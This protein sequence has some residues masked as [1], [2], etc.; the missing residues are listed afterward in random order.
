MLARAA[1]DAGFEPLVIDEYGDLDTRRAAIDFRYLRYAGSRI[2]ERAL[3]AALDDFAK[4]YGPATLCWT[5]G[6]EASAYILCALQSRYRIVGSEPRALLRLADPGWY[7]PFGEKYFASTFYSRPSKRCLV[8]DRMRAGGHAVNWR[9]NQRFLRAGAF[10]QPYL[11]GKSLSVVCL[12]SAE[13]VEIVGWNEHFEMQPNAAFPFRYS[14]AVKINPPISDKLLRALL[15]QVANK[16]GISGAFGCDVI[17]H[18]DDQFTLVDVNPR[19]TATAPLH[20]AL[21]DVLNYHIAPA[22]LASDVSTRIQ[23]HQQGAGHA[24]V[25]AD[26]PIN[27]PK[28]LNWPAW[29]SDIPNRTGLFANGEPL[30]SIWVETPQLNNAKQL[31]KRRLG[32]LEALIKEG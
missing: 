20:L 15:T 13:G 11:S 16:L 23:H 22:R 4:S 7:S 6:W 26:V 29:V 12:A 19:P 5:S 32:E 18:E 30:C 3:Y 8:K 27:L 1:H 17:L 9:T 10:F 2:D 21:K 28:K 24:V 31:L 14:A 25:Y